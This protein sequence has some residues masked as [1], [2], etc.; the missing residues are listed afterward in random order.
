M[1]FDNDWYVVQ[2]LT[3]ELCFGNLSF[4]DSFIQKKPSLH[5]ES[6]VKYL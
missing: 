2:T 6:F 3:D 1:L 4:L 5:K